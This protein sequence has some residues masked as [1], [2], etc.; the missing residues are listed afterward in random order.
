MNTW[1]IGEILIQKRLINW[2]QLDEALKEQ[3]RT[4]EFVGEVL[5]RKQYIPRFLLFKALAERHAIPFVDLSHIYIDSEA[6]DR[7]PKSVA[8]KY[9]MIPI[10][11]QGNILVV[12]ISDPTTVIPEKEIAA[13]AK[14]AGVKTVLCTPEA[15]KVAL[16]KYYNG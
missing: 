6:V 16:E 11:F 1:H 3:K 14:V 15:V 13:L 7:I 4:R 12:G 9:G 8:Q 10:E 2:A 5:V